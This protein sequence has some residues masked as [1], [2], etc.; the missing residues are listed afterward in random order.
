[1][2][3]F[4]LFPEKCLPYILG[5]QIERWSKKV[6][7]NSSFQNLLLFLLNDFTRISYISICTNQFTL[8]NNTSTKRLR[9]IGCAFFEWSL[10]NLINASFTTGIINLKTSKTIPVFKKV[11][12]LTVSNYRPISLLSNVIKIFEKLIFRVYSFLEK[13][14]SLYEH[15]YGLRK[16]HSS[17]HALISITDNK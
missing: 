6:N 13:Q 16:K 5:F 8:V 12:R 14:K 7:W 17:I 1:M 15:Q 3:H 2:N 9:G 10:T 4:K 11:S